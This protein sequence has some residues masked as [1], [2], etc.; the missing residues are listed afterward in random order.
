MIDGYA[1]ELDKYDI[2]VIERAL[3]RIIHRGDVFIPAVGQ[4]VAI[5]DD[6]VTDRAEEVNRPPPPLSFEQ[7][8]DG[9]A[10]FR[11]IEGFVQLQADLRGRSSAAECTPNTCPK[12]RAI[13]GGGPFDAPC[14]H[15]GTGICHEVTE[16][17]VVEEARAAAL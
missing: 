1:E 9:T 5:A 10:K 12:I 11:M 4:I 13:R 16:I 6:I 15:R 17:R 8:A 7:I 2:P 3:G 14:I